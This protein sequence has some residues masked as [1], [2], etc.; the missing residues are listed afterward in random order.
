M[1]LS[2]L[3]SGSIP[4]LEASKSELLICMLFFNPSRQN[5]LSLTSDHELSLPRNSQSVMY[6]QPRITYTQFKVCVSK[7]S[8]SRTAQ[9]H[10][11]KA[12]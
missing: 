1:Q 12:L 10:A 9:E 6:N 3:R 2:H 7:R 11:Q 8:P 4:C 5:L